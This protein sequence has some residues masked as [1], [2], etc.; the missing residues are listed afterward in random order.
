LN[1]RIDVQAGSFFDDV[2]EG[3]EIYLLVTVLHNWSDDDCI[4]I[5]RNCRAAMTS[6]AHLLI[7]EQILEPDPAIGRPS[8][9]LIDTQ[10]MAMFGSARER[11]EAEFTDLIQSSGMTLARIIET[12]SPVRIMEVIPI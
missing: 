3:A 11:R 9:Y 5:L 1:S 2:P 6:S 10:M 12:P 7:V 8:G 4:R